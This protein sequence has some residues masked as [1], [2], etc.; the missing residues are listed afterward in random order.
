MDLV[1]ETYAVAMKLPRSEQYELSGQIRRSV[2]SIPSNIA[3]GHTRRGGAY[4]NHVRIALGST[5][6]LD[7]QLEIAVRLGLIDGSDIAPVLQM[8][9]RVG[10]MLYRLSESLRRERWMTVSSLVLLACA[11][12]LAF[13]RMLG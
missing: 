7:T 12:G 3:E 6:E 13:V 8:N 10:Q 1:V 4:R 11:S 2:V 5:S 9:V